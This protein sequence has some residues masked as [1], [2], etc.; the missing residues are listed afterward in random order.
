[1]NNEKLYSDL[2]NKIRMMVENHNIT[3][4]P[5]LNYKFVQTICG[6]VGFYKRYWGLNFFGSIA[7]LIHTQPSELDRLIVTA[8]KFKHQGHT[9]AA[10]MMLENAHELGD[11]TQYSRLLTAELLREQRRFEE[12]KKRCI[13][14]QRDFPGF[15]EVEACLTSCDVDELL[16]CQYDYYQILNHAHGIV[17]PACY[18]EIGVASGKSLALARSGTYAIGIDPTATTADDLFFHS[19]EA[20][21]IVFPTTSNKFFSIFDVVAS[22]NHPV[23]NMAFIDG[24][25]TFEQALLDFIHL[26]RMAD[27]SSAIFIHDCLPVD[28]K[29]AEKQR[30]TKF[31]CGDVWRIIP[32]LK[33]LRP[34]LTIITLP[35]P[36][37]GLAVVTGLNPASKILSQYCAAITDRFLTMQLPDSY[38]ARCLLLNVTDKDPI[39][40][41]KEQLG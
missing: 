30:T 2:L 5:D 39:A 14:L 4:K 18:I 8:L 17:K 27:P 37:T 29:V 33:E 35:A 15:D 23:F 6:I 31:W 1:M 9:D 19:P 20:E 36:P 16:N 26:E 22:T 13:E 11:H 32:C 10:L 3:S 40:A 7:E 12:A 41:L 21:T 34:D 25:H 24:D 38:S 28:S